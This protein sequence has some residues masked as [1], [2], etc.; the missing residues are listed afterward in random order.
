MLIFVGVAAWFDIRKRRI[1]NWL[2]IAGLVIGLIWAV[3]FASDSAASS[4]GLA[5]VIG[6]GV[7]LVLYLFK[8]VGG[9]DVKLLAGFSLLAGYPG[10][11]YYLFFS[12]LAAVALMMTPLAWRGEL[13]DRVREGVRLR[14]R[15]DGEPPRAAV[16]TSFALALLIGVVWVFVM[17]AM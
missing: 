13:L 11:I 8:G 4:P 17:E 14:K 10:I 5:F 3:F 1:P 2:S 15:A 6:F 7:M 16:S 9:G 12:S